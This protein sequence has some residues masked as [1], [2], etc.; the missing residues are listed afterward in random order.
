MPAPALR[1]STLQLINKGRWEN[2]SS[3]CCT[4]YYLRVVHLE[5]QLCWA[6]A[7]VTLTSPNG[8]EMFIYT[9]ALGNAGGI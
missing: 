6:Q 9:F 1:G 2:V 5:L 8:W 4:I 7:H 3:C